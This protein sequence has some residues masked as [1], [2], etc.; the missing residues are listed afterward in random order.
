V[1]QHRLYFDQMDF[2]GQLGLL[3]EERASIND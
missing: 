3:P 1:T 2:V